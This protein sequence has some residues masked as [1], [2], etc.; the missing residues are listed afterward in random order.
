MRQI[1]VDD[2]LE[3]GDELVRGVRRQ[4]ELEQFYRNETFTFG[5]VAAI[6]GSESTSANLMKNAKRSERIRSAVFRVQLWTPR[7]GRFTN[8]NIERCSRTTRKSRAASSIRHAVVVRSRG[9]PD[10]NV[11]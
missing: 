7:E 11:A 9:D 1:G 5:V 8:R 2:A 6:N 3:P 4:V 10:A